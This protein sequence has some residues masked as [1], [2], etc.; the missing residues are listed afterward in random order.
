MQPHT[1]ETIGAVTVVCTSRSGP[2]T[3]HAMMVTDVRTATRAYGVT[4]DGYAPVGAFVSGGR[5]VP[6]GVRTPS[7]GSPGSVRY[8]S[9]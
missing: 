2:L 6:V 1:P 7:A 3:G 9:A 5:A 8:R 4:G